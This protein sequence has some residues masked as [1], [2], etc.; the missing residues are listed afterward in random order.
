MIILGKATLVEVSLPN[1]A[2]WAKAENNY[3]I[4]N[5]RQVSQ[6]LLTSLCLA[7][8]RQNSILPAVLAA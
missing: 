7:I 8:R 1:Q 5:F 2:A 4:I 3:Y 6:E